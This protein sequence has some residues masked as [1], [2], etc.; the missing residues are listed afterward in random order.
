MSGEIELAEKFLAHYA[1]QY[2]DPV[3]AH[4]YY[5]RTRQLSGRQSAKGMSDQ[6]KE[7][8]S[9]TKNQISE[10]RKAAL[11]NAA[12]AEKEFLQKA[13]A[14]A[15]AKAQ[16]IS[17]KLK[18]VIDSLLNR[19]SGETAAA[20]KQLA[21]E[22]KAKSDQIREKADQQIS[23]LPPIPDGVSAGVRAR[24]TAQR[25][26]QINRIRGDAASQLREVD[27][28][29]ADKSQKISADAQA[30]RESLSA[31]ATAQREAIRTQLQ[32]TVEK[33]RADYDKQKQALTDQ[34]E[35]TTQREYDAIRANLPSAPARKKKGSGKKKAEDKTPSS[36]PGVKTMSLQEAAV[37]TLRRQRTS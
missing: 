32:A 37:E 24:L 4:E 26:I 17:A 2:Y 7:A 20:Q 33:A 29:T 15:T 5:L 3:K 34:Y 30:K 8:W 18:E 14:D 25:Q 19:D 10:A 16:E 23:A 35:A 12:Q 21:A 13:R 1:S 9:Y 28:E 27:A 22:Q 31:E 11:Q 36:K 6:Q